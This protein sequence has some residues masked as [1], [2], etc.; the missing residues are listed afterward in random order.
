MAWSTQVLVSVMYYIQCF[1]TGIKF[2][3]LKGKFQVITKPYFKRQVSKC[4]AKGQCNVTL[5]LL[6]NIN[7]PPQNDFYL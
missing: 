3:W 1:L 7:I 5:K 6:L 2:Y 4:F